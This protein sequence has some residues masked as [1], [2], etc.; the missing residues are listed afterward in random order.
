MFIEPIPLKDDKAPKE[1]DVRIEH[2][3][4]SELCLNRRCCFYKH[5]VPNGTDTGRR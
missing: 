4:P 1:R 3:A 2:C 5:F